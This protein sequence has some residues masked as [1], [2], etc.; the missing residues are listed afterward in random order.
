M[1]E[2]NIWSYVETELLLVTSVYPKFR[3]VLTS[4]QCSNKS[5]YFHKLHRVL[6]NNALLCGELQGSS[7][8]FFS[9]N[10]MN[11][12]LYFILSVLTNFNPLYKTFLKEYDH[13][14]P[15]EKCMALLLVEE[16]FLKIKQTME[17][18]HNQPEVM[19]ELLLK[20]MDDLQI[21]KGSQQEKKEMGG[22]I[23]IVIL[24]IHN[25][26]LLLGFSHLGTHS[27]I[28]ISSLGLDDD[29]SFPRP[30]PEPPDVET[31]LIVET[32]CTQF[33]KILS[34]WGTFISVSHYPA[35]SPVLLSQEL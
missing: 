18:K 17:E 3:V 8:D 26:R 33:L 10:R 31:S 22:L 13:I 7:W 2:T 19:Q 11:M 6:P 25:D 1:Y 20:L 34:V 4:N 9:V 24:I 27:L 12:I 16:R 21:L 14:P 30:P 15:N 32:R 23:S 35:D 28:R 29:P 5:C